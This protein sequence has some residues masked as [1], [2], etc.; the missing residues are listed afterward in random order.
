VLVGSLAL[1]ALTDGHAPSTTE[2]E[3]ACLMIAA[4]VLLSVGSILDRKR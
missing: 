1:A 4:I 2:I 3:G